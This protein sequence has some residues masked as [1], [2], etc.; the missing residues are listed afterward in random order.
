ML[1]VAVVYIRYFIVHLVFLC[2]FG[3]KIS[4]VSV[5]HV[6]ELRVLLA[7]INFEKHLTY[8]IDI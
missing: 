3:N 8:L 1:L 6:L 2:H 7:L 4:P 5:L